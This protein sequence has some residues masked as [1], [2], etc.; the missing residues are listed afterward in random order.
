MRPSMFSRLVRPLWP[1]RLLAT[2]IALL[3][4]AAAMAQAADV[5]TT[6]RLLDYVA[7]DYAGAVANGRV[8]SASEY[9][10]MTEFAASISTRLGDL[11]AKPARATLLQRATNLQ[12]LIADK[13]PAE[14]V[15][16][17]ARGL[18]ADLLRAYPVPLA[19][20]KAPD[21][22]V[23]DT[24]YKQSCASCH[25][26]AGDG[27]G[28]DA[29]KLLPPPIA[30]TDLERARQR[31]VFALYQAVTQGIEG[32]GMQSFAELPSEQRWAVAFRAGSFAFTD[33]Q[34]RKGE[35]LWN[36]DPSL[37][38]RVPDLQTLVGLTPATL[39]KSIGA[40]EADAVLAFL[41][42]HPEQVVQ[43]APGSLALTRAKLAESVAAARRGDRRAAR[44]LA[45]SAYL[46]GFEPVEPTLSARNASLLGTIEGAM[47]KYRAAI[48]R[49][50][51][52]DELARQVADLGRLFDD[53]ETAL[54]P[55]AATKASTFL[56]AFT[57]L[58]REG[59]EALLIVIAMI[60]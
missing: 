57:I 35:R 11:P 23:G 51:S 46:D 60:A 21:L 26:M 43:Q 54:A 36:S 59:L 47:G 16:S 38:Q 29:A 7:V 28:P 52:P 55:D 6:W 39:A 45:L 10:E 19:P 4:P 1:L 14:Q 15:A 33:E 56:G 25:G 48:E 58:L 44:E 40:G 31:S 42:R 50:A 34:V 37:R 20:E 5:Q 3:L 24:L 18:A 2:L 32:T 49:G 22:A 9:A 30:F 41:R 17:V 13:A 8:T 12:N 27:R 53:A